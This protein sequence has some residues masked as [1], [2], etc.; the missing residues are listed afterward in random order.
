VTDNPYRLP[1]VVRPHHYDLVLEPDLVSATFT[2]TTVVRITAEES[3][4]EIVCN[5]I[6]LA[7]EEAWVRTAVGERVAATAE[8]DEATERVTFR[9][10]GTVAAGE[11]ELHC[12]FRGVLNDK[13]RGFYRST[14]RDHEGVERTIAT[15]QF[16]STN[17]RRAF[18]CWDEPD[19]KATFAV[20]LVVDDELF[21]LSCGPEVERTPTGDG[22]VRIRFADTMVMSTYLLAFIVGPLEATEPVDVN[23]TPLRIVHPLGQGHLTSFAL[24]AGAFS[25]RYF[26]E[27]F[28]IAY[29]GDKLDLVAVPDFAF[30][31]MENLG[32]VTFRE[33]LLLID[34]ATATQPELQRAADV[35]A[36]EIAH[37]WFGDLVTMAWWEGLWLKEAFATFME[38]KATDA[39]RPDWKRWVD[40]GLMK[41]AAYDTDALASTRPIEF[42]VV[43]PADAEGMYD[44][45]T[46]EK[47]AA[48]VRMLEQYLG[49]EAFRA[50]VHRYLSRHAYANTQTTDLWDALEEATG[51]PVR[52]LADTWIFQ[53]G[54]P[55]VDAST[56]A[57]R[58]SLELRQ[59]HFRYAGGGDGRWHVPVIVDVVR[60][61]RREG[62]RTLLDAETT[63]IDLGGAADAVVVNA[64]GHGFFRVHYDDAGRRALTTRAQDLLAPIERYALVDDAWAALLAGRTDAAAVLALCRELADDDDLS[65]WQRIAGVLGGLARFVQGDD[66]ARL[67]SVVVDLAGPALDVVGHEAAAD[68]D[69]RRR[70]L[71]ATLFGLAGTLGRDPAVLRRAER[72]LD[73]PAADP[74]LLAA[75]VN[76][77]AAVGDVGQWETHLRRADTAATPQDARRYLYALADFGDAACM[78]RTLR[79]CRDGDVKTQDAPFVIA[80]A[81][82]NRER[83]TEVWAFVAA[84]WDVLCERF[85][86]NSISRMVSTVT[87]I[88]DPAL[89]D[90]VTTFLTAHPVA[91]GA[92][93]VEQTLE[94]L[95]VHVAVAGR[96]GPSLRSALA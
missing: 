18:P 83:A 10:V 45:L 58:T 43:S 37:M 12:R 73:D 14:F 28:G 40:F 39:F 59:E 5:A 67:R 57:D 65:V 68:D 15:T 77:T 88:T 54:F 63:T 21:A 7:V 92:R 82:A 56:G 75:A 91:Q 3:V 20:T 17:A 1:R 62:L 32:C 76:V 81:I 50:G 36:H 24:E 72:L 90:A 89:A 35:I 29:P 19:A 74:A 55:L 96:A 44:I 4:E 94:K 93:S 66:L 52:A 13:L 9:L 69:D 6:E 26:E 16:E 86:S 85:P 95:G 64:G 38:M 79:R 31:A 78:D 27:Y 70:E 2:G 23:G 11:H 49:E 48:I 46:Y 80:R 53:G 25:L 22:R 60:G 47:G 51:Q 34:P 87:T 71:R 8:F 61:G 33:V 30:G 41:T 42:E 84:N